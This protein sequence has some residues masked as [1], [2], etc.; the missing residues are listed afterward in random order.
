MAR[1]TSIIEQGLLAA[2]DLAATKPWSELTLGEIAAK[3]G[4]TLNDFHG[5]ATRESLA[6]AVDAHFDRAM[7]AEAIA[8]DDLPR[9]NKN[10]NKK[11]V[12][13]K[14]VPQGSSIYGP[15]GTRR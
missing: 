13:R 12:H 5:V 8:T 11:A 15:S 1:T 4:L 2:L 10:Q 3:A 14:T 6:D 7:S 9:N